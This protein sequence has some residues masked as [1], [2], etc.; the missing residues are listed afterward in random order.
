MT[1]PYAEVIG[2]PIAQS[3]SPLIHNFWLEKLGIDAEYRACLV[4]PDGLE[5]YF[6][7]RREDAGWRGCN[8]TMPHKLAVMELVSDLSPL[9][10]RVG[11]ANV[12]VPQ[13]EGLA[14]GNTDATGFMEPLTRLIADGS[15]TFGTAVVIGGGGAARAIATALWS[16]GFGLDIV[17]RTR[18]TARAIADRVA[19]GDSAA[20]RTSSLAQLKD[21]VLGPRQFQPPDL[22]L[23]VNA[24]AMG[25]AGAAPLDVDL[26]SVPKSVVIYDAVYDPLET[27]LL[28]AARAHGMI[29]VD[30][31]AM[32]IGQAGEAFE[33][34]FGAPAPRQH[35]AELRAL[36]TPDRGPGQAL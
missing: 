4:R 22:S 3:K 15:L 14:A 21:C 36:L 30:G 27:P 9:A 16:A 29:T 26:A 6:A 5:D 23:I 24:S 31:L 32:L 18:D 8:V 19:G 25:M 1:K 20:I 7:R 17:N 34:F 33:R 12:V 35:D 10:K 2:D 28:R 11:A 13:Q